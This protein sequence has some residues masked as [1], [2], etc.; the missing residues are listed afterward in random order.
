MS[1]DQLLEGGGLAVLGT[2][3]QLP[4]IRD[5]LRPLGIGSRLGLRCH[6]GTGP[7]SR[8]ST[9]AREGAAEER[10]WISRS[11]CRASTPSTVRTSSA[12]S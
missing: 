9:T 7:R 1:V 4:L 3:Y 2:Q 5:R 11:I 6:A 12:S 10:R 8:D